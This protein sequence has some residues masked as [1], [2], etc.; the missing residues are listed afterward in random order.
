MGLGHI[1]ARGSAPIVVS[2]WRMQ[3]LET[4]AT[5]PNC[6]PMLLPAC[7]CSFELDGSDGGY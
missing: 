7:H 3:K 1:G 5:K 4:E 6:K 2:S